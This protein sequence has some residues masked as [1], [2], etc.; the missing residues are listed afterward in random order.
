[1]TT[2]LAAVRGTVIS[3]R[4]FRGYTNSMDCIPKLGR[5]ASLD[6]LESCVKRDLWLVADSRSNE[7]TL[8]YNDLLPTIQWQNLSN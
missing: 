4:T 8:F 6:L 1:M 3:A 5:R 7:H 2:P